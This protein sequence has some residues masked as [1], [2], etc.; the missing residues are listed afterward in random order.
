MTA[1]SQQALQV[2]QLKLTL[3]DSHPPIWRRV[4]VLANIT[5]A[6][7]HKVIQ[8]IMPWHGMHLYEFR[9][10]GNFFG[11]LDPDSE[12]VLINE[13]M[14]PL[15]KVV[16]SAGKR[17]T[18]VYDFGDDWQHEVLVEKI[19]PA[20][21]G[22]RY[23]VCTA[24]MRACPPDDSGSIWGYYDKLEILKHPEHPEYEHIKEW[25]GQDWDSETFDIEEAN[26]NLR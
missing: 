13:K 14:I 26:A 2:C 7:L 11:Q 22:V 25:M 16:K 20:E 4:Q 15:G 17:F 24:G 19:L 23:P 1:P 12:D 5:L 21:K 8:A 10:D 18:Y 3:K 9:I 6:A